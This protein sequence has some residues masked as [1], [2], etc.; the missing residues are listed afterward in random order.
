MTDGWGGRGR[1]TLTSKL[2]KWQKIRYTSVSLGLL[3]A[4]IICL[5]LSPPHACPDGYSRFNCEKN[6]NTY[7]CKQDEYPFN[8]RDKVL[9]SG[10]RN[11][12]TAGVVLTVFGSIFTTT[13][14]L[15][16]CLGVDEKPKRSYA[17]SRV[18]IAIL[19]GTSADEVTGP[20]SS[21][22]ADVTAAYPSTVA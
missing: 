20:P 15:F 6:A 22:P 11:Q 5:A 12:F 16:F 3:I 2:S 19:T 14:I 13:C 8:C 9:P 7:D 1:A 18:E 10:A 17:N 4:G 21:L